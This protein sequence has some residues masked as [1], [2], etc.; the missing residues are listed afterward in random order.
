MTKATYPSALEFA[1]VLTTEVGTLPPNSAQFIKTQSVWFGFYLF[2]VIDQPEIS[3]FA[4]TPFDFYIS[5]LLYEFIDFP[6][7]TM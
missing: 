2:G 5:G 6:Q 1:N 4:R 7:I 3:T